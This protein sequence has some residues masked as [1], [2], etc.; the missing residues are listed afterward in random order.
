MSNTMHIFVGYDSRES[1]AYDVCLKSIKL[2]N[3]A[4][5][6]VHPLNHLELRKQGL[7]K[8]RWL[9]NEE[10][11]YI[12][13]EDNLPFSTEFSHSRFLTPII[14]K[15][16]DIEGWVLFCDCD[17]LFL[18]SVSSLWDEV[19]NDNKAA[20]KCV[21]FEEQ[22]PKEGQKKMDGMVQS[23]YYR[24]LW[25]SFV[26]WNVSHPSNDKLTLEMVN[27][28]K[29]GNLHK[30]QW[31]KDEEIGSINPIWNYIPTVT[32]PYIIPSAIHFSEGGP[33]FKDY[34]DTEYADNWRKYFKQT[35][36]KYD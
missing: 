29:G 4:N 5:V 11:Q 1:D 10:G 7:F 33:W 14:A 32:S 31:L 12:D 2:N 36:D 22:N 6:F 16:M 23:P 35:I 20:I 34:K 13:L 26:M 9:V 30:F 28:E 8:R 3:A 21:Q 19:S 27:T 24:K 17:F 18:K 15:Q 25:S